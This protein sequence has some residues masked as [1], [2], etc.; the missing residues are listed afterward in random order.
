[1]DLED[2]MEE[3]SRSDNEVVNPG[4]RTLLAHEYLILSVLRLLWPFMAVKGLRLVARGATGPMNR[5]RR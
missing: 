3:E 4:I 1:M 5:C 2:G